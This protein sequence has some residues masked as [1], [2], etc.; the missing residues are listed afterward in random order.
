[1]AGL[2]TFDANGNLVSTTQDVN[3]GPFTFTVDTT[4]QVP[5]TDGGAVGS[6][7]G[8][9]SVSNTVSQ[10]AGASTNFSLQ[11]FEKLILSD[12]AAVLSI[13]LVGWG[14]VLFVVYFAWKHFHKR[15]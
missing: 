9:G 15:R 5:R 7:T 8:A 14:I 2:G 4:A 12:I 10:G 11:N 3:P 1:M 13:P 6:S